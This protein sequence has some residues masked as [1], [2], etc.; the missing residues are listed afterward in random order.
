MPRCYRDSK[1]QRV[2]AF[3]AACVQ[4]VSTAQILPA[5]QKMRQSG[6][7]P[8]RL[9]AAGAIRCQS[10]SVVGLH[11]AERAEGH[12]PQLSSAHSRRLVVSRR[13]TRRVGAILLFER[14]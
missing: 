11:F 8:G 9:G 14:T 4:V 3:A 5:E 6:I 7:I 13:Q 12:A 2:A 10:Q 1:L